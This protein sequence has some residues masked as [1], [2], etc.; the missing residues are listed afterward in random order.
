MKWLEIQK[1]ILKM[2]PE[3]KLKPRNIFRQWLTY[4]LKSK[5]FQFLL[6]ISVF[7]NVL[8]LA[9]YFDEAPKEYLSVLKYSGF[10]FSAIYNLESML[11]I[12][13]FGI[14][15]YFT[16]ATNLFEFVLGICYIIDTVIDYTLLEEYDMASM[17]LRTMILIRISRIFRLMPLLRLV[18]YLQGV[19]KI[20]KTLSN[21]FSLLATLLL[22]FLLT[23]F[24]YTII[25]CFFFKKVVVGI[26]INDTINFKNMF[27]AMITLF[28]CT[29]ADD[30]SYLIFDTSKTEPDCIPGLNCGSSKNSFFMNNLIFCLEWAYLYFIS[31]MVIS[32]FILLNMFVL[33]ILQQFEIYHKNPSNP[34]LLISSHIEDVRKT[35]ME[36]CLNKKQKKLKSEDLLYF[37][38]L[39]DIPLG[40]PQDFTFFDSCKKFYRMNLIA[41]LN[42]T[43]KN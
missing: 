7:L 1:E 4:F 33:A 15:Q 43:K 8:C 34:M 18:Q 9:I 41:Y 20:F 35:W 37:L 31:F 17:D 26:T 5:L 40:L 2:K 28:K 16:N 3:I 6:K 23:Y 39:L 19:Y 25:G 36:Y 21:A 30:W 11:K 27:Y 42:K 12:M 38:K 10:F 14:K 32:N 29:T 22:L 13:A 24:I